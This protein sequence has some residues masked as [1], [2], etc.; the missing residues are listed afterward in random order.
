MFK[1]LFFFI[2]YIFHKLK[3][4]IIFFKEVYNY[5]K[6]EKGADQIDDINSSTSGNSLFVNAGDERL[7]RSSTTSRADEPRNFIY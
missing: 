4:G 2:N 6:I 1:P 7:V 3:N 5:Q